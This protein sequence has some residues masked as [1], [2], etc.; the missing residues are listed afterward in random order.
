MRRSPAG[1]PGEVFF[2]AGTGPSLA[3]KIGARSGP[4]PAGSKGAFVDFPMT[5]SFLAL[6]CNKQA[7]QCL[8]H[9][10][11]EGFAMP[12]MLGYANVLIGLSRFRAHVICTP[13][14]ISALTL[15]CC[16]VWE[17]IAPLVNR[18]SCYDPL[19]LCAYSV[20]SICY[21]IAIRRV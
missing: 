12:F 20:G 9:V 14:R 10:G 1:T 4:V 7:G 5:G 15:F 6:Y 3:C 17:G 11:T 2:P 19:D 13:V 8:S 16:L 21:L 18:R